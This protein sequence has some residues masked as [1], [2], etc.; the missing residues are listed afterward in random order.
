MKQVLGWLL[1]ITAGVGLG[2][3]ILFLTL[4]FFVWSS[5]PEYNKIVKVEG[6][7]SEI[8]IVRD[9]ANVPHIFGTT[10]SA[11]M[12][13][14]GYVH[15]QDRLWQMTML[16]RTAQGRLAEIFGQRKFKADALVRRLGVYETARNSVLALDPEIIK[17]LEAYAAGVILCD[18]TNDNPSNG[19]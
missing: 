18:E 17:L 19:T 8:E 2:S 13:G 3:I 6:L 9:T 4:F 16:R 15:A 14:L 12:F 5:L 1:W 7:S 11:S 10:D